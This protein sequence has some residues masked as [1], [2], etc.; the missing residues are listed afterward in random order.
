MSL[1]RPPGLATPTSSRAWEDTVPDI[2]R[3]AKRHGAIGS[4]R[5]KYPLKP[6]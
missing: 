4:R 2:V 5:T 6:R 3:G 1:D